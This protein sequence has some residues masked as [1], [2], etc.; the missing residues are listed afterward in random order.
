MQGTLNQKVGTIFGAV[1]LLI[2][3]LGF[4]VTGFDGFA[5][6]EGN[7]LIAFEVN[8]LHNLVHLAI[9][10]ALVGAARAGHDS[11]RTMNTVVGATYLLV[12]IVG[13]FMLDSDANILALNQADN[14]LHLASAAVLLAVGLRKEEPVAA[15]R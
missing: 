7:L 5:S 11:A 9:G 3:L 1:Y 15:R 10:A 8:P 4:V 6:Q 13:F 2:G 14:F 12:G